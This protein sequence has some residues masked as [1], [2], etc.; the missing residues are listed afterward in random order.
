MYTYNYICIIIYIKQ[1]ESSLI[2][3]NLGIWV[4]FLGVRFELGRGGGKIIPPV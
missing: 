4:G 1:F 2:N 3:P